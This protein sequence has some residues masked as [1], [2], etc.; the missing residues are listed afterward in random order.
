MTMLSLQV[1]RGL[2]LVKIGKSTCSGTFYDL[3]VTERLDLTFEPKTMLWQASYKLFLQ[4]CA[5]S[6]QEQQ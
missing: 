6:L 2:T 4:D 3:A 1:L 5:L